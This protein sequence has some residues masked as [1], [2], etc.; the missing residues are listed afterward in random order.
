MAWSGYFT[1]GGAEFANATRTETYA[2]RDGATWFKP[3]YGN[4]VL[5]FMLGDGLEYFS[6]LQDDPPWFDP[7][8]PESIEFYGFYPLDVTGIEDSTRTSTVTESTLDGGVAGRLRHATKTVVF[9]GL[10]VGGSDCAVEYGMQWLKQLLLG[11]PC[12][13]RGDSNCSGSDLCYL[14][15]E[16]SLDLTV[17]ADD[18]EDCLTPYLRTLRKVV[19]NSGPTV[20]AKLPMTDGGEVWAVTFTA[21][22]GSPFEF[23]AEIPVLTGFLDPNVTNPWSGGEVPDG[24]EIDLTGSIFNETQCA[25]KIY[26]PLYDPLCPAVIPP[27]TPPSVGM[28]CFTPPANWR[29]RQ[30]VLPQ[31]FI[32]LWGEVAP[33]LRVHARAR[34]LRNLRLRFYADYN[35]D[36]SAADDPCSYCGDIVISFVPRGSTLTFDAATEQVYVTTPGGNKR[37]ADSLVFATDGGPFEWPRLSCGFGYVVT[38]DLPQTQTPPVIDFSLI[39][40]AA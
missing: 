36:G 28:G 37:M 20:T 39:S 5:P 40:R 25:K 33:L 26:T 23:G 4:D 7:D 8:A 29:R 18:P 31:Q 38:F 16:P 19:I 9:N 15:C 14:A 35:N 3:L 12:G 11:N 6:P 24:A 27:P 2:G 30:F 10:L 1:Y 34:D 17:G 32:P 13:G 22:A 21:V